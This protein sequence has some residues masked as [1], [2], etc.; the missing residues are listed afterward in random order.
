MIALLK[1]REVRTMKAAVGYEPGKP[2]IIEEIDID[3]PHVGEVKVRLVA[4]AI[5]HSDIHALHGDWNGNFPVV[6]GHEA[7]G[8]VEET[9]ES[10]TLTSPGD[11]VVVSLLR[12]CGRCFYCAQGI[13]NLCNGTF[14]L[15]TESRLRNKRGDPIYQ[16]IR[17]AAFAEYVIVDQSQIVQVPQTI[18][19]EKAALLACGVITGVGAVVNT[20]QVKPGSSVVVI[21]LGG[22]GLNAV[23]G[24]VLA[25]ASKI[26]A[27]DVLDMKLAAGKIFGATHTLNAKRDDA[28]QVIRDFTEGRGAD[29]VFVTVGSTTAVSQGF[30]LLRR[31]GTLVIVGMPPTGVTA[32]FPVVDIADKGLKILGSFVGSTRLRVDVPWLVDLYLQRRLKLDELIT[33]RYSLEQINEAIEMTERGEAI[34][35][36]I[37]W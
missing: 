6:V 35:N 8:V 5:C 32:P 1:E 37:V 25:G 11:N 2:L 31:A 13:T 29:Y 16:G 12:S 14:A 22:V 9:G 19:L 7:A 23:Q 4:T 30:T 24:A 3:Q 20:G 21:G 15:Q 34:R 10:V 26:I 27:M 33:A 17:T 36:V 18:P 28:R